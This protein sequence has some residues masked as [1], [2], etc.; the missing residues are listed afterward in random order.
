MGEWP[1]DGQ[2]SCRCFPVFRVSIRILVFLSIT[3]ETRRR[4]SSNRKRS[5]IS[6]SFP[7]GLINA[8]GN[9]IHSRHGRFL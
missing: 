5:V 2:Q 7:F 9:T 3:T 6:Y 1:Y 4:N 8:V